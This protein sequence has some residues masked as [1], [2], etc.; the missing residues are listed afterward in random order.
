MVDERYNAARLNVVHVL[1]CFL[2]VLVVRHV[3]HALS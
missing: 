2:N 1:R 3:T